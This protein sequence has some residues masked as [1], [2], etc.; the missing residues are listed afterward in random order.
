MPA[1]LEDIGALPFFG[2]RSLKTLTVEDGNPNYIVDDNVLYNKAHDILYAY[3]AGRE[4]TSFEVP[5]GT[6][7]VYAGAFFAAENLQQVTFHDDLQS[8]KRRSRTA[9]P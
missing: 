1:T 2:C 8:G 5:E 4:D 9:P 7:V 3:P 6:L